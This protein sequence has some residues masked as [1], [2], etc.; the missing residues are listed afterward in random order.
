MKIQPGQSRSGQAGNESCHSPG[1]W[2]VRSVD[3]EEAGREYS[4]PKSH[5][6]VVPTP[7]PRRKA[8]PVYPLCEGYIRAAGVYRP[9]HAF[10][11]ASQEPRRALRLLAQDRVWVHPATTDLVQATVW[12]CPVW[13]RSKHP[14]Q[15][16]PDDRGR[17][18][19]SGKG[20]EQSYEPI[21]PEKVGNRRAP[22]MGGHGTHW[23]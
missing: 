19:A 23:R 9:G 6:I 2:W 21:V 16:V 3:S 20:E 1:D 12:V 4:A 17:P 11:G 14:A 22:A 7:S 5:S 18:E 15:E 13:E 10:R 8:V